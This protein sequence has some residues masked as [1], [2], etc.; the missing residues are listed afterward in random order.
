MTDSLIERLRNRKLNKDNFALRLR[1]EAADEIARLEANAAELLAELKKIKSM[2]SAFSY[3]NAN[4]MNKAVIVNSV[5]H[6]ANTAIAKVVT[7]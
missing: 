3:D 6:A 4:E 7:Q 2:V 1:Y 5:W